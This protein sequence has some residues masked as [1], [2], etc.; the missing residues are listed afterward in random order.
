MNKELNIGDYVRTLEYIRKI[1][2][3]KDNY[4]YCDIGV[5]C[6]N[7]IIKSSPNITDLIKKKDIIVDYKDNIYQVV[8][9]WKG[10][11]FTDKKNK[12]GQTITLVDY[13]IKSIVTHEMFESME[14]KVGEKEKE[15]Y[16]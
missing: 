11:V 2:K 12:Y 13:Q 4:V 8:K 1:R 3:I 15:K 10:Y 9:V 7:D 14:Y 16:K 6:F 5:F